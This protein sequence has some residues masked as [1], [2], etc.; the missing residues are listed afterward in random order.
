MPVRGE[1]D[2]DRVRSDQADIRYSAVLRIGM[3]KTKRSGPARSAR[4]SLPEE[5]CLYGVDSPVIPL[6]DDPLALL[7]IDFSW[8]DH[9]DEVYGP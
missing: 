5:R 3:R 2:I 4:A 6:N 8:C 9:H 7:H 1:H